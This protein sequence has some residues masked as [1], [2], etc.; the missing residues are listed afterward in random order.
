ME[1][2]IVKGIWIPIEIWKDKNLTWNE[3]I[4]LLEIDSYTSNEKD[5]FISNE[6]I[7]ELLGINETN[8]SKTIS[9]LIKKGYIIKTRFDGRKRY[10]KA[11]LSRATTLPCQKEQPS[12]AHDIVYTD[13]NSID[14]NISINTITK[15][16]EYKE[17]FAEFVS[18]YKKMGGKVRGVD[19]EF[20]D[21]KRRHRDWRT[22]IPYLSLA[23]QRETKARQQAIAEHKFFPEPKMLQTYLGKQK[24][25]ELYVTIGEDLYHEEYTP[26]C[27]GALM[28]N[29]S[30]GC[31]LYI[32]WY[33][34]GDDIPDGYTKDSRPDGATIMLNNA[35][36]TLVWSRE[37][38]KWRKK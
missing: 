16:K 6:F 15:E 7:S 38:K 8:A 32:G 11:D 21:F 1:E 4:L 26:T 27:G 3:K 36:G 28:Y 25:W 19:T 10:V 35:R 34:D 2:R 9:S 33:T 17:K 13:N 12:R 14:D 37:T 5:C 20:D 30:S 29:E 24:A 23:V 22:I 31:Y 18:L